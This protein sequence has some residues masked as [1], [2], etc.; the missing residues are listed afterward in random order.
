VLVTRVLGDAR[1][2]EGVEHLEEEGREPPDQHRGQQGGDHPDCV[3]VVFHGN[4]SPQKAP[5]SFI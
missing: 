5:L 4:F 2:R 3:P 1:H